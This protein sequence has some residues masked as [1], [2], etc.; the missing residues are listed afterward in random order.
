MSATIFKNCLLVCVFLCISISM[1]AQPDTIP[2][3]DDQPVK[4]SKETFRQA[5]F[6]IGLGLDYG[7]LVGVQLGFVPVKHLSLFGALGYY[8][9]GTGWQLGMKGLFLPNTSDYP[10]RPFLKVMYGSNSQIKV[11]GAP[12]YNK[13]YKGFTVGF[14]AE[15]RGGKHRQNGIDLDLNVPLRTSEFWDDYNDLKNKPYID[16][17]NDLLPIAVSIGFHHEF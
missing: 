8:M 6:G 4:S 5:D 13:I 1:T 12:E 2:V 11:E 9:T 17:K 10:F 15:F 14:G 16:W 7:G 3:R